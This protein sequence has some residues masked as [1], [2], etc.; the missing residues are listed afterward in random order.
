MSK[1]LIRN[2]FN[3]EENQPLV[4]RS[5]WIVPQFTI[6]VVFMYREHSSS[7]LRGK[8]CVPVKIQCID[9]THKSLSLCGQFSNHGNKIRFKVGL[10]RT[11][12]K[13]YQVHQNCYWSVQHVKWGN[14]VLLTDHRQRQ[15]RQMLHRFQNVKQL[16]PDLRTKPSPNCSG[17]M[18]GKTSSFEKFA[19]GL[20]LRFTMSLNELSANCFW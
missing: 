8:K 4:T 10:L 1:G 12:P 14:N 19:L 16:A 11:M 17:S 20:A 2:K 18:E 6:F 5:S 3:V 7:L 13:H 9:S 15:G